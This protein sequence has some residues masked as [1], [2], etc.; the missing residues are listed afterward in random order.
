MK[1]T[2]RP[3][4]PDLWPALEHLFGS[5]GA[6]NGC[7]CMYWR[8]GA[9][10]PA[11]PLRFRDRSFTAVTLFTAFA[12]RTAEPSAA[13]GLH[14]AYGMTDGEM[15]AVASGFS[16]KVLQNLTTAS[17]CSARGVWGLV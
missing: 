14:R 8:I 2:I 3:L 4:T 15:T 16:R 12:F 5:N 1:L 6:G 10:G 7:W 11:T 13:A 9:K 17:S